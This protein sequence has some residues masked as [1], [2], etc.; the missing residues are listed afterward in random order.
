MTLHNF[1]NERIA[2]FGVM[3][4]K[5]HRFH[6]FVQGPD[7]YPRHAKYEELYDE[8]TAIF[9]EYAERL[10]AIDGAPAATMKEYLALSK[11]SEEGSEVS[12]EA[13]FKTLIK[14]YSYMVAALKEGIDLAEDQGDNVT[15][16]MF[17]GTIATFEKHLWMFKQSIK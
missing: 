15:A 2:D 6:W 10:L 14:D 11:I 1:L 12:S 7:F 8:I 13:I 3:Y 17:I 5:L 16:D 9:D 4:F